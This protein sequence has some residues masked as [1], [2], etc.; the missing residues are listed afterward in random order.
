M[1]IMQRRKFLA[2]SAAGCTALGGARVS[3]A[4][5]ITNDRRLVFIL[6]R[7]A[8]DGLGTIAP[9]GDPDYVRL[10]GA[11]AQDYADAPRLDDMF[12]LHP[13]MERSAQLYAK[14]QML[15]IH[16]V[17]SS[18]R[19]RSHF[20]GQ[21]LLEI[22]AERPYA[23]ADGWLNRMLGLLDGDPAGL[24]ISPVLPP[25]LQ[26]PS[27][28]TSYAPSRLPDPTDRFLSTIDTLYQSDETLHALWQESV[29]TR[30]V[31]DGLDD[32]NGRNA[33]AVGKLAASLLSAEDGARVAMIETTGW[34]THSGQSGRLSRAL[35]NLDTLIA[36]LQ[37]NLGPLWDNTL[38]IVATEFG[39]TAA[40]NG[41]AGT[42]HGTGSAAMLY[43][44]TVRGGKVV[45]DWPGL[46]QTD[47]YEGRDLMPTISLE[48]TIA[49]AVS[50][51][52]ALDHE[53]VRQAL[54]PHKTLRG[55]VGLI[56]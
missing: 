41:T 30:A 47:L 52:F 25:A 43:G 17:A 14:G 31:T 27:R 18:Y 44:G 24:A 38:V 10:R 9:V 55:P 26:G 7:G 40:A 39:R 3:W 34:D 28:A 5:P 53:R 37:D 36:S 2:L 6:Q 32:G 1:T 46:R 56:G 22:G 13:A 48:A 21:N 12:A 54:F 4:A 11:L 23:R 8:A 20:D 50:G 19:E 35:G 49:S 33:E 15:P 29:R 42:D 51:H 16:A 45:A